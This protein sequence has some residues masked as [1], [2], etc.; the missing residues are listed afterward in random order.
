MPE[1]LSPIWKGTLTQSFTTRNWVIRNLRRI[2][3]ALQEEQPY[4][5]CGV[6]LNNCYLSN[7]FIFVS[8]F[9]RKIIIKQNIASTK[10]SQEFFAPK[11]P[12]LREIKPPNSSASNHLF[13]SFNESPNVLVIFRQSSYCPWEGD[14]NSKKLGSAGYFIYLLFYFSSSI[15]HTFFFSFFSHFFFALN[16]SF[17]R[18]CETRISSLVLEGAW[19]LR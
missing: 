3:L 19:K 12:V 15:F 14:G 16:L 9:S 18:F 6:R 10:T 2:Q 4:A 7:Y 8:L 17:T 11:V 5:E 13:F 1:G